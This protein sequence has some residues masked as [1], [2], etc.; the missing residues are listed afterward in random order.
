MTGPQGVS[1]SILD[2]L[3]DDSPIL[4]GRKGERVAKTPIL[5]FP[6]RRGGRTVEVLTVLFL[7]NCQRIQM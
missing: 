7:E 5:L 3:T 1:H 6:P 2:I 4:L